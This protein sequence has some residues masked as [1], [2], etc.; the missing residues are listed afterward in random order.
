MQILRA[1][2]E[3]Y[4][5][6]QEP[7]G[8]GALAAKHHLGVSPATIRNDMAAL[9]DEGYLTQPHTSAG[10]IPT[11]KGYRYF[12]NSLS[13]PIPLTAEQRESIS[14]ALSGSASLQDTLQRA[15]RILSTITG[16]YAMVSAPSLSRSLMRHVELLPL[17]A[18]TLL[19]V[20]ITE[21]GRVVQRLVSTDTLPNTEQTQCICETIN[22][23]CRLLTFRQCAQS[24]RTLPTDSEGGFTPS[25]AMPSRRCSPT[26]RM[27]SVQTS[28]SPQVPQA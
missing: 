23:H 24:I 6:Q 9:E 4:I 8:S 16:Q 13:T 10:R 7:I 1:V 19:L 27:R 12:V 20:T 28:C 22:T 21:T 25:S 11:E 14:S 18:H 15:A 26:W 3:D 5:R 2:V 17:A